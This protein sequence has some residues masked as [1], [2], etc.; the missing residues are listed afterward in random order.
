MSLWVWEAVVVVDALS[1]VVLPEWDQNEIKM[2]IFTTEII[3]KI[4]GD[5]LDLDAST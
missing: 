5:R 2:K 4:G 3:S 1:L